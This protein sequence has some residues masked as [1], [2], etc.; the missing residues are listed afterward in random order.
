MWGSG[1]EASGLNLRLSFRLSLLEFLHKAQVICEFGINCIRLHLRHLIST[2]WGVILAMRLPQRHRQSVASD[3]LFGF[4]D[5][6]CPGSS[7]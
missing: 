5:A 1:L 6:E 2:P 3:F 4:G 7:L